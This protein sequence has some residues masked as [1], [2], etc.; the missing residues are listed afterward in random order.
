M[1]RIALHILAMAL[2]T[3]LAGCQAERGADEP[4]RLRFWHAWGG[5]EGQMVNELVSEFNATHPDIVVEASQFTIG[6]KLLASIAGGK[7]PD[8][9]TVWS[10][11][12]TPMGESGAF[13]ALDD[14]MTSSGYTREK[15]L[16]NVWDYGLYGDQRW[17]VPTTLN[18]TAIFTIR[19]L[20]TRAGLDPDSP[21]DRKSVV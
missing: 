16:P 10:Y 4:V 6:D 21:P 12:L 8:I 13:I 19:D 18:V 9:A 1:Q 15:Y 2:L 14:Y 17:G 5:Y 7:P 20:V 11:M 3:L